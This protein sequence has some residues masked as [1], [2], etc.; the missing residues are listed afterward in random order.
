MEI[1][2]A[3]LGHGLQVSFVPDN[4]LV[5]PPYFQDLQSMGVEVVLPPAH[6]SVEQY[7]EEH[8]CGFDL[9]IISRAGIAAKHMTTVRRLAPNARLVFDTVDLHFLREER[10]AEV[11]QDSALREEIASRREQE[12][13]LAMR[14]PI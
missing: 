2:R 5:W 9:A 11:A 7:L 10:Q 3:I 6:H 13:G 1:I 12:L 14:G 8:G 4:F